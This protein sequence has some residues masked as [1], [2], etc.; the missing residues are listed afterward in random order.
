M[1]KTGSRKRYKN[2]VNCFFF[3]KNLEFLDSKCIDSIF[4]C[5]VPNFR[6]IHSTLYCVQRQGNNNSPKCTVDNLQS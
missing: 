6:N 2:L 3:Y 5:D 1:A 4:R